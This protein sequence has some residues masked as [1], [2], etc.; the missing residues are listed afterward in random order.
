M[1]PEKE[2][3]F[4]DTYPNLFAD[5]NLPM[6]QTCMCWGIDCGDGWFDIIDELCRKIQY[7]IE[8]EGYG[9]GV[10]VTQVK[11]KYGT[12]R[13]YLNGEDDEMYEYICEAEKKSA[14]TCEICGSDAVLDDSKFWYTTICEKCK[15]EGRV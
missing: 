12:L 5:R 8:Q 15:K 11:E 10:K 2:K 6:T 7:R 3:Y 13:F 4:Y 9:D 14:Q 1:T